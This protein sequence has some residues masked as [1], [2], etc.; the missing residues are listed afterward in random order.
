M[1]SGQVRAAPG[2]TQACGLKANRRLAMNR[3]GSISS[4]KVLFASVA[5]Q[6]CLGSVYAWS[7]FVIPLQKEFGFS[8]AQTQSIFGVT[9][10]AFS[11][12]MIPAGRF[13]LRYGPRKIATVAG[14]LFASGYWV[15]ATSGGSFFKFF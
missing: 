11:L 6:I 1:A 10:A 14:I 8:T 3:M 5:V 7:T 15:A 13:L 9:I 2:R 4:G 12:T